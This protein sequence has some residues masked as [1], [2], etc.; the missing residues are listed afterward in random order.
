VYVLVQLAGFEGPL[1]G[2]DHIPLFLAAAVRAGDRAYIDVFDRGDLLRW[3]LS[4]LGQLASGDRTIG[5][6]V[7]AIAMKT[8]GMG[9]VF[10]IAVRLVRSWAAAFVAAFIVM[11]ILLPYHGYGAEKFA[12]Y[13]VAV[14]AGWL[15]VRKYAPPWV[16]GVMVVTAFLFR[17]DHGV[18]VGL[19]VALVIA[20]GPLPVL[21]SFA[22]CG[23]AALATLAPW[24]WWLYR[25][26]GI[27]NYF[28]DRAAFS[29]PLGLLLDRPLF[30][31]W[32][33]TPA[34]TAGFWL[35]HVAWLG[36]IVGFVV[37]LRR[38]HREAVLLAV[39]TGIM[40]IGIMRDEVRV[41][42]GAPL[43][44]PLWTWL[45]WTAKGKFTQAVTYTLAAVTIGAIMVSRD[46]PERLRVMVLERGG[47]LARARNAVEFHTSPDPLAMYTAQA[48]NE[49]LLVRYVAEC[50]EE[51]DRVWETSA[52]FPL[53]YYSKRRPAWHVEWQLGFKRDDESQR[54]FLEWARHQSIP[55][56]I[57]RY[58]DADPVSV[59]DPYPRVR[60]YVVDRYT[61]VTTPGFRQFSRENDIQLLVD[62]TRAPSGTF[63]PLD[64]PCFAAGANNR[65]AEPSR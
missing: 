16:L 55:L 45:A 65:P 21:R 3:W 22:Q 27:V 59:F 15:Y 53:P 12:I 25:T 23:L 20:T 26:E 24:L 4:Y 31:F 39:M 38:H 17:H 44:V 48:T 1:D 8:I 10:F 37:G 35:W 5:E 46:V 40:G 56:I 61:R 43:W 51:R 9:A 57:V 2:D 50:L 32:G 29:V 42:E 28:Y 62:P 64:L 47:L 36:A 7:L 58:R 6:L 30:R 33:S 60:Q 13:P 52:W 18:W 41:E 19:F 14:V 54:T 49:R 34:E 11:L 63:E